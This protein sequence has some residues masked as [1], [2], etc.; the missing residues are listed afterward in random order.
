MK[1]LESSKSKINKNEI[2]ENVSNSKITEA[3]LVDC[4]I[5]N[6]YYQQNSKTLYTFVPSKSFCQLLDISFKSSKDISFK[7][8]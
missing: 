1:L 6:N 7:N 5:V 2:G 8:F 3:V 4:N